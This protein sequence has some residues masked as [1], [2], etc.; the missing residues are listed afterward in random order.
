MKLAFVIGSNGPTHLGRLKYAESDAAKLAECFRL[1]RLGFE[2]VTATADDE[3]MDV[4]NRLYRAA[5]SCRSGDTF[6]CYFAGHG[7]LE[8]SALR[9]VW[10]KTDLN[11]ML[12]TTLSAET[13]TEAMHHCRADNKLLIL[14][15]CRAGAAVPA[16]IRDSTET[17]AKNL[18]PDP[19]NYL[20]LMAA[21]RWQNVR[22][23]DSLGGGFLVHQMSEILSG[24]IAVHDPSQFS[25]ADL[26]KTLGWHA[27]SH[28][29]ENPDDQVPIP[30]LYGRQRG[31]FNLL[32]GRCDWRPIFAETGGLEFS[33]LPGLR[34]FINFRSG[35]ENT[36][37]SELITTWI[38]R[39]PV[40]NR[41]FNNSPSYRSIGGP[42]G[43]SWNSQYG[44][45][46]GFRPL[47][48]ADFNDPEQPVVCVDYPA[49]RRYAKWFGE[50]SNTPSTDC[51][52][53]EARALFRVQ[54]ASD[55]YSAV[56]VSPFAQFPSYNAGRIRVGRDDGRRA[57]MP[58]DRSGS[59]DNWLGVADLEGNVWEWAMDDDSYGLRRPALH[60]RS[61]YDQD[62]GR[63]KAL[64][65]GGGF[66]DDLD[67][68]PNS[69]LGD[70]LPDGLMTSHAD[71][72]FRIAMHIPLTD[73]TADVADSIECFSGASPIGIT[74]T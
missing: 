12:S 5:D 24:P 60:V 27:A 22:E 51:I 59:R 31:P 71:L 8:A 74:I 56:G 33:L 61:Q 66:L 49:A 69:L 32:P 48:D 65:V 35:R 72:G 54:C 36:R 64:V 52:K 28:N 29:R 26:M 43:A 70:A 55:W 16:G 46:S 11:Q 13:F 3:P 45:V 44:W 14:D 4:R 20:V 42:E 62:R 18:V 6:V 67:R 73:L 53:K 63:Y 38:G 58:I 23:Y 57:P 9:L 1:R 17:S 7:R 15:C 21:D 41:Q 47:Q 2:V 10:H 25:L 30:Y 39:Y 68:I 40:T 19:D 34:Q 50:V 37:E